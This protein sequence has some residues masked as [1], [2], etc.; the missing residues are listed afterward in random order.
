MVEDIEYSY[1]YYV[2]H[3][4]A[5]EQKLFLYRLLKRGIKVF[6]FTNGKI[7]FADYCEIGKYKKAKLY[8]EMICIGHP[9]QKAIQ[10]KDGQ[11]LDHLDSMIATYPDFNVE[12]YRIE[13]APHEKNIMAKAGAGTGKTTVM[14]DRILYLLLKAKVDP[15]EIVMITFTKD[16]AHNMYTKLRENLFKRYHLTGQLELLTVIENLNKVRIQTI[17]SFCKSLLKEIGSLR[18]FG[19]NVRL[20][21]FKMDKKKWIEEELDSYL[22]AELAN[23]EES[24]QVLISPLK[25]YELVDT[26]LSFWEKFEQKG[27]STDEILHEVEFGEA[28]GPHQKINDLIQTV[29]RN[30]ERRFAIEKETLN[31]V[32]VNDL[33]RQIDQIRHD[34]GMEA[35]QNLSNPISYLFVD[36]FQDSDDVQIRLIGTIQEAF[37]ATLFVVGDVKQS[38]YRFRGANHTAFTRLKEKLDERGVEIDDSEYALTKNYRTTKPLLGQM[39]EYFTQWGEK[40][41]LKYGMEGDILQGVKDDNREEP[42]T[43]ERRREDT[44]ENMKTYIMPFV[45]ERFKILKESN[46]Q[47]P[48]EDKG[49]MAILTRTIEE[50]RLMDKWCRELDLMAKLEVGG[51]FFTSKPVRQFFSLVLALLYP[52]NGKYLA[53]LVYGPYGQAQKYILHKVISVEGHDQDAI[54]AIKGATN[55]PFEDYASRL[56][57]QPVLSVLRSVILERKPY[58]WVFSRKVDELR[59]K[60]S[61]EYTDDY[62]FQEAAGYTNNYELAIGKLFEMLHQKFSEDFVSLYQIASWLQVQIATNREEEDLMLTD[63][64]VMDYIHILTVHRAK[65]LEFDTVIIPFTER[66]FTTSFSNIIFDEARKEIGWKINKPGYGLKENSNFQSMN[67]LEDRESIQE[68][69]RLLYVAMTRAKKELVIIRNM[70]NDSFN[71]TW[72][73]LLTQN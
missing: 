65:G 37:S 21:S 67:N 12:Q 1:V 8:Q 19:L 26:L 38:I 66:P 15:A 18:G 6:L 2:D 14:I 20:R 13:H 30:V 41:F 56:A 50:A 69:T 43:I 23:G 44:K 57:S 39:G 7:D 70:K 36:E 47:K 34:H 49:K 60:A 53:N 63:G 42:L 64:K 54:S 29:I 58:D 59:D 4:E 55:F 16:A 24:I 31:A 28:D 73:K 17:D 45:K 10:I 71:W 51:G 27:F 33:T 35:F 40:G 46:S 72:S 61:Y 11:G 3:K 32:T 68:E 25:V 48:S 52:D 62:I 5:G 9:I 22:K